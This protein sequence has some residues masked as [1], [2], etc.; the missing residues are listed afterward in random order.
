VATFTLHHVGLLVTDIAETSEL[1]CARFGYVRK[2]DIV[3]DPVQCAYVQFAQL[4][5]EKVYVEFI[6]P[7]GPASHLNNALTASRG[8]HHLCYATN[9]IEGACADL[10]AKGMT[11]VRAPAQAIAFHGRRVAW[12]MD[13]TRILTELVEEGPDGE[14]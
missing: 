2:S 4:P 5:G 11:L 3:H 10:R 12:L 1:Y 7:D 13:R 6:S 14:L 9:D 8:I